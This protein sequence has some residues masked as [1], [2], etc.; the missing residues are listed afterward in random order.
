MVVNAAPITKTTAQ[1]ILLGEG[2][3]DEMAHRLLAGKLHF[4]LE[5]HGPY[6]KLRLFFP[7]YRDMSIDLLAMHHLAK[8]LVDSHPNNRSNP[9]YAPSATSVRIG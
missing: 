5:D 4:I 9:V 7:D 1:A 3:T 2:V 6:S 8:L